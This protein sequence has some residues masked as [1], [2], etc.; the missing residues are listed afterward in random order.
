[1]IQFAYERPWMMKGDFPARRQDFPGQFSQVNVIGKASFAHDLRCDNFNLD[2]FPDNLAV[3]AGDQIR[4]VI[5]ENP[6]TGY[7]WHTNASRRQDAAIRE[8]Y[9]GFEAP[10]LSLIGASGTRIFVFEVTDPSAEL[11]LGL[12]RPGEIEEDDGKSIWDG[13]SVED[14]LDDHLFVKRIRFNTNGGEEERIIEQ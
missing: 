7:W 13:Y 8:I 3:K 5:R 2:I 4:L 6:T 10:N 1:M 12:T 9:N 14:T 11:R